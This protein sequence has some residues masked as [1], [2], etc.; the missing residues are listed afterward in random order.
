MEVQST[1]NMED[2]KRRLTA[3]YEDDVS[4][5]NSSNIP[6]KSLIINYIILNYTTI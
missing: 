4:I 2:M 1:V 5:I 3:F 6:Y